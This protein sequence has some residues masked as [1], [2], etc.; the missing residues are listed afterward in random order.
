MANLGKLLI[1]NDD[2]VNSPGIVALT[3]TCVEA[4]YEVV[5][6]A[7][8]Y[9]ASGAGTSLNQK[10]STYPVK[11]SQVSNKGKNYHQIYALDCPPA[12]CVRLVDLGTFDFEPDLVVSGINAGLN[13]GRSVLFSGTVGAAL[14]AQSIGL[15]GIALSVGKEK[16]KWYYENAAEQCLPV[17][18]AVLKGPERCVVN[19]NV[20]PIMPDEIKGARWGC[21]APFNASNMQLVKRTPETIEVTMSKKEYSPDFDSDLGLVQRDYIALTPLH[22][23]SEVW[24][25]E[26]QP[27]SAF[28]IG[29]T[30]PGVTAGDQITPARNFLP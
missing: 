3:S 18:D 15:R 9:N 10:H 19:V 25:K 2:G 6:A 1:T 7:P 22:G 11:I 4:G 13:A 16:D 17:I 26:I 23:T 5:V 30:V 24:S 20:P 14:A 27:D 29:V 28:E 21:L 8:S 12:M